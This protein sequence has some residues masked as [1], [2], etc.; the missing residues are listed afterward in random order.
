MNNVFYYNLGRA[1]AKQERTE[2]AAEAYLHSTKLNPNHA[3]SYHNLGDTLAQLQQW[4]RAIIAYRRALQLEPNLLVQQK[5]ADALQHQG[6][7][8]LDRAYREYQQIIKASP[9]NLNTY[10]QALKI[11]PNN[12]EIYLELGNA[13]AKQDRLNE[14][15]FY[16]QIALQSSSDFPIL[17]QELEEIVN[18]TEVGINY[19]QL[20]QSKPDI[21]D[22]YSQLEKTLLAENRVELG[23]LF[24]Q[25]YIDSQGSYAEI[26]FQLGNVLARKHYFEE[27][28]KYYRRAIELYSQKGWYHKCLADIMAIFCQFD[29]AIY[30][31]E[32]AIHL[33]PEHQEF[34]N[35]LKEVRQQKRQWE[36][37]NSYLAN[38]KSKVNEEHQLKILMLTSY[39]PYPP[40]TGG[41]IR[42]F[43]EIKYLGSRHHLA[44]VS[45]I[46]DEEE[47]GIEEALDKYCDLTILVKMGAQLLPRQLDEP[48]KIHW[49]LTSQMWRVLNELKTV[50]FDLVL[51]DFIFMAP[52]QELFSHCFTVLEEHN[53][54]SNILKQCHTNIS[55]SD[56]EAAAEKVEAVQGFKDAEKEAQLLREYENKVWPL[57]NLRTVVSETDKQELESRYNAG[58]TLVVKNGIDTRSIRTIDNSNGRKLF[59]MG[60][61]SYYPNIDA[62][63]YFAL[64][65]LPKVWEK[66]PTMRFC[67]AGRE[68]APQVEE[69]TSDSRIELIANP[70]DMSYIAKDCSMTV[71]PLRLGSGTRIKI[72]H[73]MAMGLPVISTSMGAEGL[74]AVDGVNILIRDDSWEFAEAILSVNS[75]SELRMKLSECGRQLVESEYDWYNIFAEYEK[76]LLSMVD[77]S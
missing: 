69:L 37:L 7:L 77:A 33:A 72:L 50:D 35:K 5:L 32:K 26:Y 23:K 36:K 67:I 3:G 70:E 6:Q 20:L 60:H 58:Q 48:L 9:D 47:Y 28:L 12:P 27:A 24:K 19:Y 31:Y 42:M 8:Y 44:V 63:C 16:Y 65:I 40:Q 39:P 38:L 13:L 41:A 73:S 76:Q 34:V 43:E 17:P 15:I 10:H 25:K 74:S 30:A 66:E 4:D 52:Y 49:W 2:E 68:P 59:Y 57:F 55:Q 61:M 29:S 54:E 75:D 45:F 64:E 22:L 51:F 71:V 46:F 56:V 62:V 21:P 11:K 18:Q 53:I 1:L 14:A